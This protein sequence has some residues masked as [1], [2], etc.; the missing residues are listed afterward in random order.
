MLQQENLNKRE[1][2]V[3]N[4]F[5]SKMI[6]AKLQNLSPAFW[7]R[8]RERDKENK[9]SKPAGGLATLKKMSKSKLDLPRQG[10]KSKRTLKPPRY[11]WWKNPLNHNLFDL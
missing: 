3:S 11:C 10:W 5:P 2:M 9:T 7:G 1:I 8:E 4:H 6:Q